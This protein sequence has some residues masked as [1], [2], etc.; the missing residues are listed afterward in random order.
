MATALGLKVGCHQVKDISESD[1][2]VNNRLR[3]LTTSS[4]AYYDATSSPNKPVLKRSVTITSPNISPAKKPKIVVSP[5]KNKMHG[6]VQKIVTNTAFN[7][8]PQA[9]NVESSV[10]LSSVS[11]IQVI[12]APSVSD[13]LVASSIS[14]KNVSLLSNSL[15]PKLLSH[16]SLSSV[17]SP[18][19]TSSQKVIYVSGK[20]QSN[21]SSVVSLSNSHSTVKETLSS[22]RTNDK[23]NQLIAPNPVGTHFIAISSAPSLTPQNRLLVH[24]S[25][26]GTYSFVDLSNTIQNVQTSN[27]KM[28]NVSQPVLIKLPQASTG[29]AAFLQPKLVLNENN[30]LNSASTDSSSLVTNVVSATEI[31]HV[32]TVPDQQVTPVSNVVDTSDQNIML[33]YQNVE[34]HSSVNNSD[35][36]S[37]VVYTF[38]SDGDVNPQD[39]VVLVD[40]ESMFLNDQ[41][42]EDM[43]TEDENSETCTQVLLSNGTEEVGVIS[44]VDNDGAVRLKTEIPSDESEINEGVNVKT[45]MEDLVKNEQNVTSSIVDSE[46]KSELETYDSLEAQENE[47]NA[48]HQGG[49]QQIETFQIPASNIYQTEDGLIFI[50]NADGTTLQL[51]GT[52]GQAVSMETVQ[53]LLGIEAETQYVTEVNP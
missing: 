28:N 1:T 25:D 7:K 14:G 47:Q 44:S 21:A 32:L 35:I 41:V 42:N 15:S 24:N 29:N 43:L 22:L 6:T 17:T 5:G 4:A 18:S 12:N 10:G 50:Q 46:I 48:V 3:F 40:P 9:S 8:L 13:T 30:V 38:A 51:Q 34:S 31:Q 2:A 16:S 49:T 27:V 20:N 45:P 19:P 52:D 26:T 37:D 53:A 23:S 36:P 11:N 33:S 39:H